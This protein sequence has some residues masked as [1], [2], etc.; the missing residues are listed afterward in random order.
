MGDLLRFGIAIERELLDKF[1]KEISKKGYINRS[2]AIRDL[3]RDSLIQEE[4]KANDEIIGVVT[5]IYDHHIPNLTEKLTDIQ[6]HSGNIISSMHIHL[7]HNDC[8][9]IIVIKG[10][11]KGVEKVAGKIFSLKGVKH[12]KLTRTTTAKK[13]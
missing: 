1:D 6:H 10:K 12:G 9:E 8:L 11:S 4:W 7:T 2:E 5:F 3:M 13:I